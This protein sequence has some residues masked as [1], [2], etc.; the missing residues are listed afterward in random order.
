LYSIQLFVII[1]A[2]KN[3]A[4]N[5]DDGKNDEAAKMYD[6]NCV[7][8]TSRQLTFPTALPTMRD[9]DRQSAANTVT[10]K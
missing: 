5:D 9:A 7:S 2:W 4:D 8:V 10:N 6:G 3:E 1:F